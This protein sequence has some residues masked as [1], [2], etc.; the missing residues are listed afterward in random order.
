[1]F[2]FLFVSPNIT[3]FLTDIQTVKSQKLFKQT[4][5]K[6]DTY[7]SV[8]IEGTARTSMEKLKAMDS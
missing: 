8:A 7:K 1:M 2:G 3:V 5:H 6:I 4:T